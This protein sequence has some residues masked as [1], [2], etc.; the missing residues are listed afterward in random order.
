VKPVG[1]HKERIPPGTADAGDRDNLVVGEI[2][3][4]D[5][6]VEPLMDA[7]IAASGAP[8]GQIAGANGED[9]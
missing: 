1:V 4:L 9:L 6:M 2:H 8:C 3:P 7:E 5:G